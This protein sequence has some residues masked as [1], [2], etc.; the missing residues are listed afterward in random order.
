M[1]E[2]GLSLVLLIGAGLLVN[3]FVR[4]VKVDPGVDPENV[5]TMRVSIPP[6]EYAEALQR[7][8]FFQQLF[9]AVDAIPGTE[10]VGLGSLLPL[11]GT[12]GY[13][14]NTFYRPEHPPET[15]ADRV[16]AML[17]WISPGY[18]ETMRIPLLRGRAFESTDTEET[19]HVI[20]V[21]EAMARSF[22]PGE[23]PIGK[24]LLIEYNSW[25]GEIVGV[26][27]NTQQASLKES[28]EPHMYLPFMQTYT[29]MFLSSM[30]VAVR[31]QVRPEALIE[32][33]RQ[34]V[35]SLDDQLAPHDVQTF[36]QR[37]ATSVA[38]DRFTLVLVAAF[39]AVAVVLSAVGLYGVI[40]Y[41]VSQRTRE[42][43]LRMAL[44]ARGSDVMS[45][46][47]RRGVTLTAAGMGAGVAGV[48]ALSR[49]L[50]QFLYGVTATDPTTILAVSGFLAGVAVLAVVVPARRASRVDP[51]IALRNE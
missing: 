22:F 36:E 28:P 11:T 25:E 20:L 2:V 19:P 37:L 7:A 23:D 31:T 40:A 43:G 41:L 21:D 42:M 34:A 46:V 10:S 5:L 18:L 12:P 16:A 30:V 38:A 9:E 26:V 24:R 1:A 8:T 27:G 51:V 4:L 15:P 50:S 6:S 29:D 17:R 13:W 39:A 33:I 3:S 44:G 48:L 35:L 47:L 49:L 32:P 45:L 14:R